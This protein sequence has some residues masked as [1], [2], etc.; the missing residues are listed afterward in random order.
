[1]LAVKAWIIPVSYCLM[2][3]PIKLQAQLTLEERVRK[4]SAYYAGH[5]ARVHRVPVE[6][7]GATIEVESNWRPEALSPKGAV[8][9]MQ[10]MPQTAQR[11][12]VSNRYNIEQNIRGGV[13]LLARLQEF[14]KGDLRLVSAAYL[15]GEGKV[16]QRGLNYSNPEVFIYVR[17]IATIY[18]HKR[19]INLQR[20]REGGK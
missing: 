4:V 16:L 1:M 6:L 11:F 10:L 8:G 20:E 3:C 9:L 19:Q 18:R 17:K 14:F 13:E 2:V 5:Y 12:E 15:A 7:V